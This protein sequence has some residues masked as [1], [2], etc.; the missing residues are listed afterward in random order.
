[1]IGQKR[2]N[3]LCPVLDQLQFRHKNQMWKNNLKKHRD[4]LD[5]V[6]TLRAH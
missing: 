3:H 1:M 6:I 5:I 2:D 4:I